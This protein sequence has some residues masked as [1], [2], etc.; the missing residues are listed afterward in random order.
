M[1]G[2]PRSAKRPPHGS[3][4]VFAVALAVAGCRFS[5]SSTSPYTDVRSTDA[6]RSAGGTR[7]DNGETDNGGTDTG[8]TSDTGGADSGGTTGLGAGDASGNGGSTD[9]AGG[10]SSTPLTD[11]GTSGAG[12]PTG[13]CQPSQLPAICDP[14]H[15]TGCLVP[16]TACDIDPTQAVVAG[17]CTFPFTSTPPDAGAC[18]LNA[19]TETCL[20]TST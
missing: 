14:V 19:T 5:G 12:N 13:G 2:P 18:I 10:M 16:F 7:G 1:V 3:A 9:S 17:R 11:G 8:G 15:N 20:P 4:S 6:A